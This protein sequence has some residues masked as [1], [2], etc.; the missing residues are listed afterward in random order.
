MGKGNMEKSNVG[1][2]DIVKY[3]CYECCNNSGNLN[4][5]QNTQQ[6]GRETDSYLSQ[7]RRREK[8]E[9]ARPGLPG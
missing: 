9:Y 1:S 4:A 3:K 6:F 8:P 5:C 7:T 2:R